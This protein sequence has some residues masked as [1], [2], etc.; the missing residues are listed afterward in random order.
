MHKFGIGFTL[1]IEEQKYI[2]THI[3]MRAGTPI[4][5]VKS[6][7]GISHEIKGKHIDGK[8]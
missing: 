5:R 2:C 6:E 4:V 1:M 7:Q 8:G 3:F